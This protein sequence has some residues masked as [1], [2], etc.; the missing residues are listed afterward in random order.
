MLVKCAS[1][2]I[3][4][5]F[6]AFLCSGAFAES[7]SDMVADCQRQLMSNARSGELPGDRSSIQEK[8]ERDM[9]KCMR[10]KLSSTSAQE[11]PSLPYE[12]SEPR[13]NAA[14]LGGILFGALLGAPGVYIAITLASAIACNVMNSK[15]DYGLVMFMKLLGVY[16][17]WEI[18]KNVDYNGVLGDGDAILFSY[19]ALFVLEVLTLIAVRKANS[20]ANATPPP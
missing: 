2:L 16:P 8:A 10:Q 17:V 20:S 13:E 12:S 6:L 3:V 5:I 15:V 14:S 1:N 7:R 9:D 19:C 11:S 4:G 18:F